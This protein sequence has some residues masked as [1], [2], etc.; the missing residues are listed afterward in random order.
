MWIIVGVL[1]AIWLGVSE[2]VVGVI[3]VRVIVMGKVA[4]VARVLVRII[5][6]LRDG[7]GGF[8]KFGFVVVAVT[9]YQSAD[10]SFSLTTHR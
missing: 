2:R 9:I 8:V 10:F 3:F 7:V 4:F 1:V 5:V 6:V